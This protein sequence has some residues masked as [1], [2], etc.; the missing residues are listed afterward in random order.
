MVKS[1][2]PSRTSGE[3]F[4]PAA[5]AIADITT[6]TNSGWQAI[7]PA[8]R[9]C[10]GEFEMARKPGDAGTILSINGLTDAEPLFL[11]Q[12]TPRAAQ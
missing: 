8:I 5:Q 12:K 1:I 4:G 9:E 11:E 2:S 6:Q 7:A 10:T 3:D